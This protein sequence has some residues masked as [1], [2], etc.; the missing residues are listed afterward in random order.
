[1]AQDPLT[2]QLLLING[3]RLSAPIQQEALVRQFLQ[4]KWDGKA[5]FYTLSGYLEQTLAPDAVLERF[6]SNRRRQASDPRAPQELSAKDT[7]AFRQD[8]RLAW[9]FIARYSDENTGICGGTVQ[10]GEGEIVNQ[11]VSLWDVA[12]QLRGILA[13]VSI[14]LINDT[15]A[16]SRVARVLENL[17]T[18]LIGG[19]HLPPALFRADAPQIWRQEF[20]AC[21]TGRFL[22]ALSA[23]EKAGLATPEQAGNLVE[24]W[25]ISSVL[26]DGQPYDFSNGRWENAANSHCTQY[27]RNGYIAW[28]FWVKSAYPALE[29][30]DSGDQRIG[31][32][33]AAA[34][35]GHF[36]TEPLLLEGVELGYSRETA[37]L[38]EV[39]FDAQ[40][41]W[42]EQTGDYKSVS[43]APLNFEPW[44]SYQGLRVD[45]SGSD[46]WVIS[47]HSNLARYT[48][49]EFFARADIISAKAAFLW[50][51]L[52]PH[53]Y[54]SAVLALIREKA[55]LGE[56]AGFSVGISGATLQAIPNYSDVNTNGIILTAIAKILP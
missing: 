4:A 12:S 55:R 8:A 25:D 34:D 18:A 42:F 47:T 21:D 13:A 35:I 50:V 53:T 45:R 14:G 36:G 30:P 10:S 54:S 23:L 44:F 46:S 1:M 11:W 6:W 15:S 19:R 7:Q 51:A 16:K 28:G 41:S 20:N 9:S 31:L 43:E 22:L 56:G 33:Y 17:P 26:R 40:L 27:S 29:D 38:S 5:E 39:L 49:A 32:L 52:Y 24:A 37:Y 3:A 2:D 48:T